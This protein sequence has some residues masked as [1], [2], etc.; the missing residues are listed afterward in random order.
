VQT[1]HPVLPRAYQ[2]VTRRQTPGTHRSRFGVPVAAD[3]QY[4]IFRQQEIAYGDQSLPVAIIGA[5]PVG[6]VAAPLT[7][8][9]EAAMRFELQ[10]PET[11]VCSA[12]PPGSTVL[13]LLTPVQAASC[14]G[15]PLP[16]ESDACCDHDAEANAAGQAGCACGSTDA[17]SAETAPVPCGAKVAP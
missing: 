12:R 8:D 11:G 2:T 14:C 16:A 17:E 13:P 7:G 9:I 1:R 10:L 4:R 5:G 6:P 15:G 3:N